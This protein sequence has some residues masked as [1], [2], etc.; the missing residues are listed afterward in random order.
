MVLSMENRVDGILA[1]QGMLLYFSLPGVTCF[2]NSL[3]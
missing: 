2:S 1:K 3:F